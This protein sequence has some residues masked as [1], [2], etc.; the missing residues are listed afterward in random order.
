MTKRTGKRDRQ[1]DRVRGAR[2][3]EVYRIA[4]HGR[5]GERGQGKERDRQT[6]TETA[7]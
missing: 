1:T 5:E 2:S 3:E 4:G 6:E 7:K